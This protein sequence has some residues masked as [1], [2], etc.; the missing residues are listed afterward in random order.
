MLNFLNSQR[1][2]G[3]SIFIFGLVLLLCSNIPRGWIVIVGSSLV[4]IFLGYW[5]KEGLWLMPGSILLGT[6]IASLLVDL[7][8]LSDKRGGVF[9]LSASLGWIFVPLLSKRYS[10]SVFWWTLIPGALMIVLGWSAIRFNILQY[11]L[12][13]I[14]HLWAFTL[15]AF[16]I[17]VFFSAFIHE[18]DNSRNTDASDKSAPAKTWVAVA[19]SLGYVLREFHL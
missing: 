4:M 11:L 8:Q 12:N 10:K 9:I 6:A 15:V 16:G 2:V 19:C 1:S 3:V 5:R 7:M 18:S 13:W 14:S 17:Y